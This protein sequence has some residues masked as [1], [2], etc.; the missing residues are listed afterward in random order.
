MNWRNEGAQLQSVPTTLVN[1]SVTVSQ[2]TAADSQPEV[3]LSTSFHCLVNECSVV[4]SVQSDSRSSA[5]FY[6][7]YILARKGPLARIWVAAHY[8]K[9]LSKAQIYE[10]NIHAS[11][12]AIL[13]DKMRLALRTSGHLLLGVVRIYSRQ[14]R[15]L[16]ADCND[17]YAKIRLAFRPGIIDLPVV[18]KETATNAVTIPADFMTFDDSFLDEDQLTE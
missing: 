3:S 15:Y 5:M 8:D 11:V 1:F 17:A 7:N 14:I 16:L 4:V 6:D 9:K 12:A 10:V 13:S 2:D 18:D